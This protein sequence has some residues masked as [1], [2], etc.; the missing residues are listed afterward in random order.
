MSKRNK[1]PVVNP[2]SKTTPEIQ[3]LLTVRKVLDLVSEH[4]TAEARTLGESVIAKAPDL[5]FALHALGLVELQAKD[6]LR[7]EHW[8]RKAV[9]L[10]PGNAEYLSNLGMAVLKQDRIDDAIRLFE[11]SIA[12]D[13]EHL[14]GRIGL[15]DA[16]HEKK[17]PNASIAYF[18]E[19]VR[20][21]P[22]AAGPLSHLGKAL[23]DAKRYKEAVEKLMQA[24]QLQINFAPAHTNLGHA[25]QEMGMLE[26]ALECHI[27]ALLLEPDN[28]YAINQKADTHTKLHDYENAY[29]LYKKVIALAPN[30]PNSYARLGSSY[31]DN[32]DRYDE[33][34]AMLK[35]ALTIDP[36]HA[37][38]Y[39]NIGVIM[40]DHGECEEALGH[41]ET[42]LKLKSNYMMARHNMCLVQLLAGDF[43]NGWANHEVRLELPERRYIYE[44]A[45][46]LFKVIPKWDGK[47]SLKD[48]QIL[49]M[50]EQGYGDSIQF[51]RY[52]PMLLERGARVALH[53]KDPL[54]RLFASFPGKITLVREN[55]KLPAADFAYPI[56]SLPYGL[57][58]TT[59][60]EIPT[61]PSYLSASLNDS[62][63]WGEKIRTMN[64]PKGTLRVGIVWAGNPEHGND[65]RRS[66]PLENAAPLFDIPG[67][68]FFSLQK[69]AP[70]AAMTALNS[71][72]PVINLGDDF[73]DFADTAAA[74]DNLDLVISVD[75][76]V[77]HL[78]GALGKRTW[79]LLAYMPDWRWLQERED[80][81]WYPS[82]QL[83]RQPIAGDWAAVIARMETDLK[84]LRDQRPA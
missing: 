13:E 7:S 78:A 50:H 12:I 24:L 15:A 6:Y 31:Y 30:D 61:F 39:N 81:P 47:A 80:S 1:K 54:A 58:T 23:I 17:D 3:T 22:T 76:S 34:I 73:N 79:A 63:H 42:A 5:V 75:T 84:A 60:E 56:M 40:H 33:S 69:G 83:Y 48:K 4:K 9:E 10:E 65:R 66:M 35:K 26:E 28:I 20:R 19:A 27:T 38:T 68:Q 82:M 14:P 77:L 43:V 36:S 55:D 71:Q 18:E 62:L 74:I 16:L 57:G 67:V 64:L 25:F 44:L 52:V 8:F 32:E 46:E 11:Q 72:N 49:L 41:F 2:A 45:L 51:L 21:A 29:D 53:V 70:V 59:P 37:I